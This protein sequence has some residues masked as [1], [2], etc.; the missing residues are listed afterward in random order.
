MSRGSGEDEGTERREIYGERVLE[1]RFVVF[2]TRDGW[3]IDN[4]L[5][6]CK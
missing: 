4:S 5:K 2:S 3:F 1:P 6:K